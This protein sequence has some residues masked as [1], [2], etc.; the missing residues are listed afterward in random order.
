MIQ[1]EHTGACS[2]VF[3]VELVNRHWDLWEQSVLN[4]SGRA[5]WTCGGVFG[6]ILVHRY[7]D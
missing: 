5:Y 2:E 6:V 4:D 1:G 3:G 7:C